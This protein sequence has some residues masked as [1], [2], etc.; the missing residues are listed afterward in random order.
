MNSH[1]IHMAHLR[2]DS[3][4]WPASLTASGAALACP[5]CLL[6]PANQRI[7]GDQSLDCP[8]ERPARR[9]PGSSQLGSSILLDSS[10]GV[11][12]NDFRA[13]SNHLTRVTGFP[14]LSVVFPVPDDREHKH[15]SP[16]KCEGGPLSLIF[17]PFL[18]GS[19]PLRRTRHFSKPVNTHR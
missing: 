1:C 17:P 9:A 8:I 7:L 10:I 3:A 5:S 19:G 6:S 18:R 11:L 12:G 4:H 15:F 16:E 2:I 14:T 13:S